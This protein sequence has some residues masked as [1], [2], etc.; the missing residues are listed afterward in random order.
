MAR[1]PQLKVPLSRS[2]A[3][4]PPS[5]KSRLSSSHEIETARKLLKLNASKCAWKHLGTKDIFPDRGA[6]RHQGAQQ[7]DKLSA[8]KDRN[9]WYS[10]KV[11]DLVQDIKEA[12]ETRLAALKQFHQSLFAS[13]SEQTEVF[14]ASRQDGGRDRLPAFAGQGFLRHWRAFVPTGAG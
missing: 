11:R 7:L 2:I 5:L 10:P 6:C 9:R 14:F 3:P 13:F 12:R 8:T 1:S 4:R